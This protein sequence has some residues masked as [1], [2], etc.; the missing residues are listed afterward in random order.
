[1]I[2]Y[3]HLYRE[4][5]EARKSSYSPYSHFAVGAALLCAGLAILMFFLCLWLS[6]AL[7]KGTGKFFV[8]LK[9]RLMRK[10]KTE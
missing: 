1:M 5:L 3:A 10:E 4:A 2:D 8:G 6:R 7:V 9:A